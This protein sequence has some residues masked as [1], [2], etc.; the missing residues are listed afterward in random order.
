MLL[1]G[2]QTGHSC[3]QHHVKH[4]N[5]NNKQIGTKSKLVVKILST[6]LGALFVIYA[7]F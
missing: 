4:S 5:D 7:L 3:I 2:C 6:N 1:E